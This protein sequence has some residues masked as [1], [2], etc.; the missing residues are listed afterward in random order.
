[1]E[2]TV[3]TQKD[4]NEIYDHQIIKDIARCTHGLPR[5]NRLINT[6]YALAYVIAINCDSTEAAQLTLDSLVGWMKDTIDHN[7]REDESVQ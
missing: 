6:S 2:P 5:I 4:I 1:M 7:R 3:L